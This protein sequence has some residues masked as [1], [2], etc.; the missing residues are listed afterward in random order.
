MHALNVMVDVGWW[1]WW[2]KVV[3]VGKYRSVG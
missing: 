3:V 1:W 2:W